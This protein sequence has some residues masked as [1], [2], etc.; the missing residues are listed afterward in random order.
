MKY[1][2]FDVYFTKAGQ[3]TFRQD[4]REI[5]LDVDENGVFEAKESGFPYHAIAN[6]VGGSRDEPY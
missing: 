2:L 3:F 6:V 1:R 4:G 5:K